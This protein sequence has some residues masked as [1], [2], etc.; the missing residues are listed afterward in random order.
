MSNRW[1]GSPQKCNTMFFLS[2]EHIRVFFFFPPLW[3]KKVHWC[4]WD[5]H[6]S[7]L[8]T[9]GGVLKSKPVQSSLY[10]KNFFICT[11]VSPVCMS[12]HHVRSFNLPSPP[13]QL[14][15]R[16]GSYVLIDWN[17]TGEL[18]KPHWD[19]I[20]ALGSPHGIWCPGNTEDSIAFS[21]C[22]LDS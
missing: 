13:W 2:S 4:V 17:Y 15:H 11:S 18:S 7:Q 6:G 9:E 16:S 22:G 10:L 3:L 1:K 8:H 14:L 20:W 21:S 12:L 19:V 5:V